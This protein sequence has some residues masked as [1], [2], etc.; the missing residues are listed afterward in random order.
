MPQS[1]S[2][3]KIRETLNQLLKDVAKDEQKSSP[4]SSQTPTPPAIATPR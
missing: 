3:A 4:T 1:V 2:G